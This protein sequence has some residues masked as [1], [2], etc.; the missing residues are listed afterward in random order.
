MLL[1]T[2]T[3]VSGQSGKK[4]S[5]GIYKFLRLTLYLFLA[6][7]EVLS[8][9]LIGNQMLMVAAVALDNV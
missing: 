9:Y 4:I 8:Y 1:L 6:I 7:V 3:T 5:K 2:S